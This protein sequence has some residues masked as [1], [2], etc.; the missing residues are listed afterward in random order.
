[1]RITTNAGENWSKV[2]LQGICTDFSSDVGGDE[3]T[4]LA[5]TDYTDL[6][7]SKRLVEYMCM[8]IVDTDG[9]GNEIKTPLGA[10][11][12][13][14]IQTTNSVVQKYS[15]LNPVARSRVE[16]SM[17]HQV[18]CKVFAVDPTILR[19]RVYSGG[20]KSQA[21]FRY[22]RVMPLPK[23]CIEANQTSRAM[24][25]VSVEI[26]ITDVVIKMM[27][28]MDDSPRVHD[29]LDSADCTDIS[30]K[31]I[32]D[33]PCKYDEYATGVVAGQFPIV[34]RDDNKPQTDWNVVGK[35][36]IVSE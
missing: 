16:D 27:Q 24:G 9:D 3:L 19:H 12:S 31:I 21:R 11:G 13:M 23:M 28:F 26:S 7:E 10:V 22:D 34:I 2:T 15:I 36:L 8:K 18:S 17:A 1:M 6:D 20:V 29:I 30:M 5:K 35:H 4:T 33:V 32:N 14:A 25:E